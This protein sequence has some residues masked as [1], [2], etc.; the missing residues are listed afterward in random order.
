M[1]L[2]AQLVASG[3]LA[4]A[5]YAL[6][7][8]GMAVT[9]GTGTV[10]LAL[11]MFFTLGAYLA[12]ES[13][14]RGLPAFYAAPAAALAALGLGLGIERVFVRPLRGAPLAT[15]VVLL[16]VAVAGEGAFRLLWGAA[17]RSVPLRLQVVQIEHVVVAGLELFVAAGAALAF[18]GVVALARQTRA[19][20]AL[21]AAAGSAE[22]AWCTG[23]DVE[24]VRIWAFAAGCAAAA[25]AGAL[26]SPITPLS[27]AMGRGALLL[28]LAAV[29][30]G[31]PGLPGLLA[32]SL[33]LGV[34]TQSS[35]NYLAP[36]WGV[37]VPAI[38][39]AGAAAS[40][41]LRRPAQTGSLL[42]RRAGV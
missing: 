34:V 26:A 30:V 1:D 22:I 16:A 5:P 20:L 41:R 14:A 7:A 32:A 35:A 9:L 28:S 36:Q 39:L 19:G 11:G 42:W 24:R 2:A 3:L 37:V 6:A 18:F 21:R 8:W 10:N 29:T 15:A 12:L 23:L 17:G 40:K 13:T 31:G 25:A 27:P 38:V 4:G 33:A